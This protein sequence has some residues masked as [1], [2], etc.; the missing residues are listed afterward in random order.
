MAMTPFW[1]HFVSTIDPMISDR[2]F[3]FLY[4]AGSWCLPCIL[5]ISHRNGILLSP[6]HLVTFLYG[7][8]FR[9]A[10]SCNCLRNSFF[11]F[12][13]KGRMICSRNSVFLSSLL[14][15]GRNLLWQD[16]RFRRKNRGKLTI[17][18]HSLRLDS[19]IALV[20]GR[21]VRVGLRVSRI[22]VWVLIQL[23][24]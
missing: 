6:G 22:S 12:L 1:P 15:R 18:L 21:R 5:G 2:T 23:L 11:L 20:V 4:A 8:A 9:L 17:L 16:N 14:G 7:F 3:L 19:C 13:R 10:R 24:E